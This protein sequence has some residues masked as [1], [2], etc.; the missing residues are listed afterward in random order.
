MIRFTLF[1]LTMI[2][3]VLS[4][5]GK[6][7]APGP[8]KIGVLDFTSA[9][10]EGNKRFLDDQKQVL[11]IPAAS[12]LNSED[13]QSIHPVMQGFVRMIDAWGTVKNTDPVRTVEV[14]EYQRQVMQQRELYQRTVHGESRPMIIGADYLRAELGQYPAIF[15]TIEPAALTAAMAKL[16]TAPDFPAAFPQRLTG[17]TGATHLIRG[18]VSDLRR[19]TVIF[20]GYGIE[21]KTVV[22]QLDLILQMFD[23]SRG[24]TVYSGTYTA[25]LRERQPLSGAVITDN[26]FQRLLTMAV[27]Q[28]AA[29]FAAA[30]RPGTGKIPLPAA[31]EPQSTPTQS[32]K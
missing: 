22:Y 20:R 32:E 3:M 6:S 18:T 14:A 10:V 29:D 27:K 11:T 1:G 25:E 23:L 24:A 4:A 16:T 13:R 31:R 17:L 2:L 9:D 5:A 8:F 7:P 19:Q 30:C 21:T 28:G 26:H 12:T 15:S